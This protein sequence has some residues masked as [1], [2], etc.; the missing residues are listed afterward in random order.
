MDAHSRHIFDR[1]SRLLPCL[2][3]EARDMT[4][5]GDGNL[6]ANIEPLILAPIPVV[7]D[8]D[9]ADFFKGLHP[10]QH[11]PDDALDAAV[12]DAELAVIA[13]DRAHDGFFAQAPPLRAGALEKRRHRLK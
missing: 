3:D 10:E 1:G 5:I 11:V 4:A 6:A 13:E 8:M 9:A 12:V 7:L 2:L